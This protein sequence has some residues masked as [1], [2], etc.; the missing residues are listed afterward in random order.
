MKKFLKLEDKSKQKVLT[1]MD[2]L[3]VIQL[4][5]HRWPLAA[6]LFLRVVTIFFFL[7]IF[8]DQ[9]VPIRLRI[10]LG[11]VFSFFIYPIVSDYIADKNNLLQW[12]A[13]TIA[14]ATIREIIFAVAVGFSAKLIF[15]GSSIASHLV[16]INMG[17]QA[18][19][20]FNPQLNERES[21][22]SVL[23][24]WIVVVL[25]LSLN[26]H[27]FFLEGIVKSFASVPIGPIPDANSFAKISL[28]IANEAF[29]LGLRLAA[30]LITVQILINISMGLLNR[31]LPALNVFVISFPISFITTMIILFLSISSLVAII[32]T[33]GFQTELM[34]FETMK[35]AFI[36]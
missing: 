21:S 18:A 10:A 2:I 28:H 19:S 36:N 5:P 26:I 6:M 17:F 13:F 34:W 24:N 8:G 20:M 7:P 1:K 11:I 25:L 23:Q 22:Y 14:I 12:N 27:H 4:D 9:V 32:S 15:F 29:V 16:G 30:P 33:Y 31:S 35:R 3:S